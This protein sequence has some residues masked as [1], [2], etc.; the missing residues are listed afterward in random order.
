MGLCG[1]IA[2]VS[3]KVNTR[4]KG[5]AMAIEDGRGEY[6]K[7]IKKKNRETLIEWAKNNKGSM[8]DCSRGT[9]ISY[10]CVR[11][12]FAEMAAEKKNRGAISE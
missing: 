2:L 12:H 3:I 9:G 10:S 8:M 1:I 11:T 4:Q 5:Q 6:M 7:G